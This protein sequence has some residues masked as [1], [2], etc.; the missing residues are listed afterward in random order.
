VS[1]DRG[2]DHQ[3]AVRYL[4]ASSTE[5]PTKT[6]GRVC[7]PG[8]AKPRHEAGLL[9]SPDGGRAEGGFMPAKRTRG[10]RVHCWVIRGWGRVSSALFTAP[11]LIF[12]SL[13]TS[14]TLA[15]QEPLAPPPERAFEGIHAYAALDRFG[16]DTVDVQNLG[17]RVSQEL[18]SQFSANGLEYEVVAY[19]SGT[20]W[21]AKR[22][23]SSW[24]GSRY[25]WFTPET[26]GGPLGAGWNVHMGKLL[27]TGLIEPTYYDGRS[28][29]RGF[30][31]DCTTVPLCDQY[32]A[33]RWVKN[34]ILQ[35]DGGVQPAGSY[36]FPD[37]FPSPDFTWLKADGVDANV[38]EAVR[39]WRTPEG[40][41]YELN[42]QRLV[43]RITDLGGN[44]I[45]ID[46]Y[47]LQTLSN[48]RDCSTQSWCTYETA[49]QNVDWFGEDGDQPTYEVMT[50]IKSIRDSNGRRIDFELTTVPY[51]GKYR[52]A[53]IRSTAP[54]GTQAVYRLTYEERDVSNYVNAAPPEFWGSVTPPST[55]D[56]GGWLASCVAPQMDGSPANQIIERVAFLIKVER[57]EG[58]TVEYDYYP[59][60]DLK[61]IR[62]VHGGVVQYG[63]KYWRRPSTWVS[64][65]D[66]PRAATTGIKLAS[67]RARPR[68][69]DPTQGDYEWQYEK[70]FLPPKLDGW[71]VYDQDR[72]IVVTPEGNDIAYRFNDAGLIR[73][74]KYYAGTAFRWVQGVTDAAESNIASRPIGRLLREVETWVEHGNVNISVRWLM[75]KNPFDEGMTITPIQDPRVVREETYYLDDPIGA[76]P[77][78][79]IAADWRY[80]LR[81]GTFAFDD[82]GTQKSPK[83]VYSYASWS[84]QGWQRQ[85]GYRITVQEGSALGIKRTVERKFTDFAQPTPEEAAAESQGFRWPIAWVRERQTSG[86]DANPTVSESLTEYQYDLGQVHRIIKEIHRKNPSAVVPNDHPYSF[87]SPGSDGDVNIV[88]QLWPKRPDSALP[89]S[90]EPAAYGLPSRVT[91]S[92]GD[93][94]TTQANATGESGLVYD[95]TREYQ[96]G[97]MSVKQVTDALGHTTLSWKSLDADIKPSGYAWKVRDSALVPTVLTYDAAGDLVKV[98][99][100]G[101]ES[102]EYP[103]RLEKDLRDVLPESG[104]FQFLA[105]KKLFGQ[106]AWR[107]PE[108]AAYRTNSSSTYLETDVD[109]LVRITRQ[110]RKL[111]DGST[112]VEKKFFYG[113][114]LG[115]GVHKGGWDRVTKETE[116]SVSGTS[117]P[118]ATIKTIRIEGSGDLVLDN[119]IDPFLREWKSVAA[120]SATL[121]TRHFGLNRAQTVEGIHGLNGTLINSRT[122]YYVDGLGRVRIVDGPV[123]A[124]DAYHE[125]DVFGNVTKAML[126]DQVQYAPQ[127]DSSGIYTDRFGIGNA[128]GQTR[129]FV[130]DGLGR[131]RQATNP[132]NG[133]VELYA[134]DPA[135]KPLIS[136]DAKGTVLWRTYDHAGRLI[137]LER[138]NGSD[139]SLPCIATTEKVKLAEFS[140]HNDTQDPAAQGRGSSLGKLLT[141][142]GRDDA[143]LLQAQQEYYY[144]ELNGRIS[145]ERVAFR[146]WQPGTTIEGGTSPFYAVTYTYGSEGAV[147]D[148]TYPRPVGSLLDATSVTYGY[149]H[150]WLGSVSSNR[151]GIGASI[152]Y[153]PSGLVKEISHGN[154]TKTTV[155]ADVRGRVGSID[156]TDAAAASLWSTGTH[157]YDQGGNLYEIGE[158]SPQFPA[159][160]YWKFAY[161]YSQRLVW[162]KLAGYEVMYDHDVYG[163]LVGQRFP[164]GPKP[165]GMAFQGRSYA[166]SQ[167][168]N[169]KNQVQSPGLMYDA[170]NNLVP[171]PFYS[172]DSNGDTRDGGGLGYDYDVRSRMTA[173]GTVDANSQLVATGVYRYA[174]TGFR[175]S[176]E[177]RISG[178]TTFY[179]RSLSGEALS[180]YA[181]P[182]AGGSPG[183]SRDFIYGADRHLAVV[184]NGPPSVPGGYST[185]SQAGTRTCGQPTGSY[186]V[187]TVDW[188]NNADPDIY[189]YRL[190]RAYSS[191]SFTAGATSPPVRLHTGELTFSYFVDTS[192]KNCPADG[193]QYCWYALTAVDRSSKESGYSTPTAIQTGDTTPPGAARQLNVDGYTSTTVS[194]SWAAPSGTAPPDF[195][196]YYVWR[197]AMSN[198]PQP[199]L[200]NTMPLTGTALTDVGLNCGVVYYYRVTSIDTSSN[201]A[202]FSGEVS[203]TTGPCGGGGGGGSGDKKHTA[204]RPG[205]G[206]SP[207]DGT[208]PVIGVAQVSATTAE[209]SAPAAEN[210]EGERAQQIAALASRDK[211]GF[212]E[213]PHQSVGQVAADWMGYTLHTDHLGSIR[214][215]TSAAGQIVAKHRYFPFGQEIGPIT[216]S[217]SSH[218]YLGRE[219]DPETGQLYLMERYSQPKDGARFA[220]VDPLAGTAW[221][222]GSLNRYAYAFNSPLSFADPYGLEGTGDKH[223]CGSPCNQY[224]VVP[225]GASGSGGGAGGGGGSGA[226]DTSTGDRTTTEPNSR[227]VNAGGLVEQETGQYADLQVALNFFYYIF[228]VTGGVMMVTESDQY[229]VYVGPSVGTPGLSVTVTGQEFGNISHGWNWSVQ[230][231]F[232]VAG[233]LGGQLGQGI[234]FGEA[235]GGTP[236]GGGSV[237]YVFGPFGGH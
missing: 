167:G 41:R 65:Y 120:D 30:S 24:V 144:S 189:G 85:R 183:W 215:V 5:H 12:L 237:Y 15:Q 134:Y 197:G 151:A 121:K 79:D 46:Y 103:S 123:G 160:D 205:E 169:N 11:L 102:S 122:T 8:A 101:A 156:V 73:N 182:N 33:V 78:K 112:I 22:Y 3:P 194:V 207:D 42:S 28:L 154:G 170:N 21:S 19:Y 139:P 109:G 236:G 147:K 220:S 91:Q 163:N 83:A 29:T 80:D 43:S 150:G 90:P 64:S 153:H 224:V 14:P 77:P 165:A 93:P 39:G 107:G 58:S 209:E 229:Y 127:S 54:D 145:E 49:L 136:K 60:G 36:C 199:A 181:R 196:G 69:T 149:A 98:E 62:T 118:P 32:N 152:T 226:T 200:V 110:E 221:R 129:S 95:E 233:Q 133:T 74:I 89:T 173:A 34:T 35:A 113:V 203:A 157:R 159:D 119:R 100:G 70:N 40:T 202:A 38:C 232:G 227:T 208:L 185:C 126:V 201:Q 132:E 230:G 4:R 94:L 225:G 53:E 108:G 52:I 213:A 111:Q 190:Y 158:N 20:G 105:G 195:L 71:G 187:I 168:N 178:W 7:A 86:S 72:T 45:E 174:G 234:S 161:D 31:Q 116:W 26:V 198:D 206:L 50:P 81:G 164:S 186:P 188:V 75:R 44:R 59:W 1:R 130:F 61:A 18:S 223:Y 37:L 114:D 47:D 235:G 125:Y 228:G 231:S 191:S 51:G 214:L 216:K 176:K 55:C 9:R 88:Y 2:A 92:G 140:Y 23:P 155:G 212:A 137:R 184:E 25:L 172:Y 106:I 117:T 16:A 48:V 219:W 99:P 128:S 13:P 17:L 63:W 143:G 141:I 162:A 67:R 115:D 87:H 148:V 76:A 193:G 166:D 211:D 97:Q 82:S 104:E 217:P 204:L 27:S 68:A 6:E 142:K 124:A 171:A 179:I 56:A 135:G 175:S 146:D 66:N 218:R 131:M 96:Y 177:D 10:Q 138:C 180:E 84:L 210:G 57:P 192:E 222:P